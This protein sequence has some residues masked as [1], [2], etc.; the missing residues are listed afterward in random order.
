MFTRVLQAVR[1]AKRR[2]RLDDDIEKELAFH[3]Q[4]EIDDR[5]RRGMTRDE[6][7]RTALRD[8]G[9][10]GRVREEVRDVRG[11]NFWGDLRRDAQYGLRLLT[12]S[13]GYALAAILTLALGI[14]ANAAV[15][16]VVNDVLLKPLPYG[17]GHELI[18]I[19]QSQTFV[20]PRS[21]GVSIAEVRDYREHLTTVQDVVEYHAL[22]FV[23]LGR[24]EPDQVDAG[25]VSAN[26]FDLFR[27][28][29]I[30][31]RT[32]L[33]GDDDL[34]AEPVLVLS[35]HYWREKFNADPQVVGTIV[36]L[37]DRSHRIVG[38]LP[39]MPQYPLGDDV[40]MPTSACPFRA[41]DERTMAGGRRSFASL[42]A[43][44]RLKP[45]R[46]PAEA[47]A[48]VSALARQWAAAA[49][50][51]YGPKPETFGADI[52]TLDDELQG[53]AKPILVA[54]LGTTG[55]VLLIAC[56]N[57]ANLSLARTLRRAREMAVRSALGAGRGRLAR[58]LLVECALVA[59]AGGLL[60]LL[61]AE[62]ST[63]LL[64]S[65]ASRFTSRVVDPTLDGTVLLFTIGLSIL[66]GLVFGLVP[67]LALRTVVSDSVKEGGPQTGVG[68]ASRRLRSALVVAQVTVCF[69]LAV[70]AGLLVDS[71]YRLSSVDLGFQR[72]HVLSADI[73]G[74]WSR[75]TSAKEEFAFYA[76][77]LENVRRIP[78]V[79]SAA[80]TNA[81]P[82]SSNIV[83]G[84]MPI[85]IDGI[86][87][88]DPAA[89]PLADGN[90]ATDGYF[91]TLGVPILRGR[92][93]RA[94][95]RDQPVRV[96]V[97]NETMA[98]L[99]KGAEPIGRRFTLMSR[100]PHEFTVVG[101][102]RDFRQY[103]VANRALAQFY[104]PVGLNTGFGGQLLVRTDS[105]PQGL[106][107]AIKDA[108]AG[109]DP[110][111]PVEGIRTLDTVRAARL[112]PARL[113]TVLL[114]AFAVL[115]LA[116]TLT[117]LAAV[118][119]TSVSQR[120]REFGLRMALGASA[121]AVLAMVVRQGV[122]LVA[123][124]LVAGLAGAMLFGRLLTRYLYETRPTDV[125]VLA[126]V[127]LLFVV[128][129]VCACLI[130]ARRATSIDPLTALRSE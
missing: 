70:G 6:A 121:S 5:V 38:V 32:F 63:G 49:P 89:F 55:L 42:R 35:N 65:F 115:A 33:A 67:A 13:P 123:V 10:V 119:A 126:G 111:V 83:P 77:A 114:G 11:A 68:A 103:D 28:K 122:R 84:E 58:Q 66:T 110:T 52:V 31:G 120:T 56:A 54:L 24:G 88:T 20:T 47:G 2:G 69:T 90:L 59:I 30:Y 9:G 3:L 18:R 7:R 61:V 76:N 19:R 104:A 26:Y 107:Q 22:G 81:V 25:V 43:F 36:E 95:D 129:G 94:A 60:G 48:E 27:V 97:I 53:T 85:R 112:S 8:F 71:L 74:N 23:M 16:S 39:P 102:V 82:L 21:V 62:A 45:G 130:P 118:I 79:M 37:N 4:M 117:G 116:I 109:I 57:V 40:Y 72:R 92:S 46:T 41:E 124:G 29:P 15:F 51:A 108:V 91:E 73:V 125:R 75:H 127:A 17:D 99:W 105:D 1:L 34:E 80:L 106:T 86:S 98:K 64:A 78:G 93:L 96:A 12:R 44:A 14:G 50:A 100:E 113:V 101:V 87:G 128:A